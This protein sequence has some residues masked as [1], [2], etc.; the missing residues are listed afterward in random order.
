MPA[1]G[2]HMNRYGG[3]TS[4][5]QLTLAERRGADPRR[6][7]RDPHPRARARPGRADPHPAHPPA[8]RP[9]PGADV[10]PALL[11]VRVRDHDLGPVVAGGLARGPDRPLHLGAAVAGRGP[12]AALLGRLPR[13][14]ARASGT[15]AERESAPRRSPTAGPTLGYRITDGETTVAYIPDH[16]PALGRT[17]RRARAGL[18]L[19]LR[20]GPRR[21][22]ADPRLPVHRRRVP[23][24][25]SA[26]GTPGSADTLTF[27]ERVG[28]TPAAALPPRP[29]ARRR[30]PR[31]RPRDRARRLAEPRR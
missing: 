16:E 19:G 13:R 29:A 28:A 12:R 15:W 5:V 11:Q 30:V 22:P 31:R 18:D 20:P 24:S 23:A 2:P 26:G 14:A 7:H 27:A 25:T 3:N 17:A 4:C 10:L 9:H 21:R 6:R 8:P 1:P